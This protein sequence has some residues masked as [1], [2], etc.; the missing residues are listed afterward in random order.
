MALRKLKHLSKFYKSA[1]IG[2]IPDG[3]FKILLDGKSL[4]SPSGKLIQTDSFQIA[5]IV[6]NEFN[7]QREYLINSTMPMVPLI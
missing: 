7:A 6:Q 4:K 5:H 3:G 1:K 2:E